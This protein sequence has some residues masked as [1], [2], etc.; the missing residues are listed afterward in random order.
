MALNESP[1]PA[2]PRVEVDVKWNL[3]VVARVAS[4]HYVGP[5]G[6]EWRE[7]LYLCVFGA[8]IPMYRFTHLVA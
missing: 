6:A 2:V 8:W 3:F 5:T 4:S 7:D 1:V